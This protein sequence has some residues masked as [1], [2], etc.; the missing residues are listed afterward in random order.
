M[1]GM[2]KAFGAWM[3]FCVVVGLG[4]LGVV[5]WALISLVLHYT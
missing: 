3:A 4:T 5:L 2:G 1:F